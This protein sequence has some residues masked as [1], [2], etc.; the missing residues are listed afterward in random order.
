MFV[1]KQLSQKI[2]LIRDK[3]MFHRHTV[4]MI[5]QLRL[6]QKSPSLLSFVYYKCTYFCEQWLLWS[7]INCHPRIGNWCRGALCN[8]RTSKIIKNKRKFRLHIR[9]SLVNQFPFRNNKINNSSYFRPLELLILQHVKNKPS[10]R[11]FLRR[12]DCPSVCLP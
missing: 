8:L 10:C 9:F 2:E 5:L 12:G 1:K 3:K 7:M 6:F 4:S 11:H